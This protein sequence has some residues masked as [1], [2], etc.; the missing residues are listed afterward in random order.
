MHARSELDR[1]LVH[2]FNGHLYLQRVSNKYFV[3]LGYQQHIEDLD[4]AQISLLISYRMSFD[5]RCCRLVN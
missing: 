1:R 3:W 2:E 5:E 4:D